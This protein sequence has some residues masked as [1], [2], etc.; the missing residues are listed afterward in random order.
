MNRQV[1]ASI[2]EICEELESL[3]MAQRSQLSHLRYNK[4]CL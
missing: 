3:G 4:N 1:L 2:N